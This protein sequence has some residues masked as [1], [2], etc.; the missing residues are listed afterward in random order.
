ME[1]D[2]EAT[3]IGFYILRGHT[4]DELTALSTADKAFYYAAMQIYYEQ[5]EASA[6][7]LRKRM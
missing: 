7:W 2:D 3:M 5:K 6:E 4:L 1:Q